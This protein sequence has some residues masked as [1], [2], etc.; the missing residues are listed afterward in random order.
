M[1]F[2]TLQKRTRVTNT[3]ETSMWYY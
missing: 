3:I 2:V 1:T